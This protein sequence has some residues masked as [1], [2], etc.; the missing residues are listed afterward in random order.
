MVCPSVEDES[1]DHE[2]HVSPDVR[3]SED[4]RENCDLQEARSLFDESMNERK[5]AKE[6]SAADV[7]TRIEDLQEQRDL[8]KDNC[9]VLLWLQHL[10]MV[11]ILHQPAIGDFIFKLLVHGPEPRKC[12]NS[13]DQPRV[14]RI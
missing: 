9:T 12:T 3:P 6:V 2:A 11:D 13:R 5:S 10:D 4:G 1:Y 14:V 8:M 7:L